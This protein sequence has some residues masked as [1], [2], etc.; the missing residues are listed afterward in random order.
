MGQF[1]REEWTA[2]DPAS[3]NLYHR[4][5]RID[6]LACRFDRVDAADADDR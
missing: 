2:I 1:T 3:V 5:T 4:G 6:F